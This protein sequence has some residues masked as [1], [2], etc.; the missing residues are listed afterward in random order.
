MSPRPQF[1]APT[2][3]GAGR[4]AGRVA[5]ITGGDSGIG[6]S[7]AVLFA[8]EGANVAIVYT[9][10]SPM[11]PMV[12]VLASVSLAATRLR[13]RPA[14]STFWSFSQ[15]VQRCGQALF[16]HG[17]ERIGG[18]GGGQLAQHVPGVRGAERV[19]YPT[20]VACGELDGD[21]R[22]ELE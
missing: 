20:D 3:R 5:L 11:L 7:V 14:A 17:I 13:V 10:A 9:K 19:G 15:S 1:E 4:L 8:R 2:Y 6:R 22:Y 12:R 21:A 16:Q 18:A